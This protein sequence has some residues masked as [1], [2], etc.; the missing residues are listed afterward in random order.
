M[1]PDDI[2]TGLENFE[3][4]CAGL[5]RRNRITVEEYQDAVE[6]YLENNFG[7]LFE[8]EVQVDFVPE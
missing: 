1:P 5:L 2:H 4:L 8:R 6:T 7:E 3:S